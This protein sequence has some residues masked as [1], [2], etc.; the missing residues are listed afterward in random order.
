MS[1]LRAADAFAAHGRSRVR[2]AVSSGRW[3]R[4][5]RGVYVTHNGPLTT[6]DRLEVALAGSPP[7]AA[8]AGGTAITVDGLDGFEPPVVHV[9]IPEGADRPQLPGVVTHWSTRLGEQ[10]V[11]PARTPRRTRTER[12]VIDLAS[13]AASDRHARA[14]VLAAFQQG[15]VE[16]RGMHRALDRRSPVRRA[17]LVRESVLDAE[18]GL[19]SLPELDFDELVILAGLPTPTRQRAVR[20]PNGRYYLDVEWEELGVAVEIHGLPHHGVVQWSQDL[21][22]ANEVVIAGPRL[23]VFTSYVVRHEPGVVLD[24]LVR[25]LRSGGWHGVVK[26]IDRRPGRRPGP[27][28]RAV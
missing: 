17:G 19:Q 27:R 22:R 16:A 6:N 20:A 10:D 14:A 21:V 25:A 3:Q 1:V 18:G 5:V 12:S 4:P 24:Q 2:H 28:A 8:L 26:P 15:L 11:H 9:A 7:G 13:W 23:L